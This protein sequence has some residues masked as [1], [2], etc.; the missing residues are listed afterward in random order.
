MSSIVPPAWT[1]LIVEHRRVLVRADLDAAI[2]SDGSL[3]QPEAL[4]PALEVIEDLRDRDAA[5]ILMGC[6]RAEPEAIGQALAARGD[7]DLSVPDEVVGDGVTKLVR[8]ARPR[9]VIL[10]PSIARERDQN[11]PRLANQLAQLGDVFVHDDPASVGAPTASTV[12][13]SQQIQHHAAGPRLIAFQTTLPRLKGMPRPMVWLAGSPVTS[14][15]LAET[16]DQLRSGDTLVL[17][18]GTVDPYIGLAPDDDRQA[19]LITERCR[20]RE[21][22]LKLPRDLATTQTP[23]SPTDVLRLGADAKGLGPGTVADLES[24]LYGAQTVLWTGSMGE[25]A[26]QSIAQVIAKHR[27]ERLLAFGLAPCDALTE[28][29]C[30]H[31]ATLTAS[32]ERSALMVLAGQVLPGIAALTNKETHG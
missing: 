12:G 22:H 2:H 23:L 19:V 16:L 15:Q 10:L 20:G 17:G 29:G 31:T 1:E 27:P 24:T 21:I 14:E 3:V 18:R 5:V 25:T 28:A 6:Y 9:D 4:Y 30:L 32:D 7:F 13:L 8:D 11:D 26:D